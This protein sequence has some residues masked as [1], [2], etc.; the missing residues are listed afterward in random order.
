MSSH[1]SAP[2]VLHAF[3]IMLPAINLHKYGSTVEPGRLNTIQ[4]AQLYYQSLHSANEK[5]SNMWAADTVSRHDKAMQ[6][7]HTWLQQLPADL[8]KTLLTCTPADVLGFM[9]SH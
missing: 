7:V 3:D 9:E 4:T 6:E 8:G 5:I 1:L 2:P